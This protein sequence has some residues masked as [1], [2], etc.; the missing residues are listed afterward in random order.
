MN[1]FF[2]MD[3]TL[4]GGI[5]GSVRP[6]VLEVMEKLNQDGHKLY[7]WSGVGIRWRDVKRLGIEHLII[8][9]YLKPMSNYFENMKKMELP[10]E[11]DLVIDDFPMVASG[12]GGM[13]VP[14]YNTEDKED[15]IMDRLYVAITEYSKTGHSVDPMYR[16]KG[17]WRNT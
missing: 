4:I 6:N 1:I 13:C 12:I 15:Q 11:P 14:A 10:E 17:S 7:V 8:D 9:C 5:D 16:A 3:Y 2:D